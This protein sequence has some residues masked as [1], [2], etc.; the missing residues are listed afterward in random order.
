MPI[1]YYWL[2]LRTEHAE[3]QFH[4]YLALSLPNF[5]IPTTLLAMVDASIG[6]KTAVDTPAGK[7]LI[8]AFHAPRAVLIDLA[9]LRT[10]GARH[11]ANGCVQ[12]R[13]VALVPCKALSVP[14]LHSCISST[15]DG[16]NLFVNLILRSYM[17]LT[18]IYLWLC[19]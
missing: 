5:Q 13:V 17:Q 14:G 4:R 3:M 15:C 7:N 16:S 9:T 11:V 12:D 8:G 2:S 19:A 1:L 6:G 18:R 10:L